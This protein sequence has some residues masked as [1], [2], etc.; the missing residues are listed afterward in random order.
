MIIYDAEIINAVPPEDPALRVSGI[1][2][3]QGWHDKAG[4]GIACICAYDLI[5]DRAHVFMHDNLNDFAAMIAQE[6]KSVMG[7]NNHRFDDPLLRATMN[8]PYVSRLKSHDLAA[9]IYEAAGVQEGERPSG[10]GLDA[11][12]RAN[13]LPGK[14]GEGAA[15]PILYQTQQFGRLIDYCLGDIYATLRLYRLIAKDGGCI[16]P[17]NGDWLTVKVTACN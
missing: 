8:A 6:D 12:C 11:V 13:G 5:A 17:R 10:L 15:A 9:L 7:W 1:T 16:D 2:Y 14:T 3:C 4:M